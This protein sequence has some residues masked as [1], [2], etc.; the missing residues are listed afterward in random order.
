[1][2]RPFIKSDI[3][4]LASAHLS[5]DVIDWFAQRFRNGEVSDDFL[6]L[7]CCSFTA[8]FISCGGIGMGKWECLLLASSFWKGD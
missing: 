5:S 8:G 4:F 3:E 6:L 1:M 2:L 7:H